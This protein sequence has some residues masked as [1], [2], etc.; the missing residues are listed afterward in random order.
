MAEVKNSFLQSKMNKDL[1]DRLIPNGQYRDALN[2]S[3]GKA[4]NDDVGALEAVLGN[5]PM[6]DTGNPDLICIGQVADNQNN[7][8]FQFW[9]DYKDP[10]PGVMDPATSGDMR[11]TM[12]DATS[13]TGTLTTLVS[14]VFLNF[15][16]NNAFRI[17]GANVLEDL[18]FWTDNRNQPRK[19]N[20]TRA[21]S[22]PNYYTTEV[23]ISVAKYSPVLPAN[24][25]LEIPVITKSTSSKP[26][27][28]SLKFTVSNSDALKLHIGM[29]LLINGSLNID[30]YAIITNIDIAL[31]TPFDGTIT[32][33]VPS[34]FTTT[35]NTG[36]ILT[37]F[38]SSMTNEA[39]DPNWPGDPN[40]LKDKYIRMSYRYKFDDGEYSLMAP[41]TQVLFIPNQNGYFLSG[42]EDAAYRST[43]VSWMENYINN[44]VLHILLP[45]TGN[46]I[47][48][49]YKITNIE[50]LYKESESLVVKALESI[51]LNGIQAVAGNTNL[52]IYNYRS[53]KPYKTLPESQ[54]VRVYD[55]VPV[56][57]RA[58][59]IVGNRVIYGNYISQNTPPANI[60][61]N[62]AITKKTDL[63]DSWAEYPNHTLKQNRNYQVGIILADKFGR[64]SS[65]ILSSNDALITSG[66]TSFGGSTVY[67]PYLVESLVTSVKEWRGN[68][69]AMIINSPITSIRNEGAGTPGLYAIVDGID[70]NN[71]GFQIT[72]GT[73]SQNNFSCNFASSPAQR[74]YPKPGNY[75]RGK[76]TDYV[77]VLTVATF[78]F[79]IVTSASIDADGPISDI[80]NYTGVIPDIK[81]SYD[82]NPLG[83]YSYKIVVR[84]QQQDYYNV[85]L[86]GILNGYPMF[87]TSG[88]AGV[89][90][91]IFPSN[92]VNR[93]AH[94]VLI[95]DN[96]NKIPRDLLEVGPDQKQYRSSVEIFGRVENTLIG[97]KT[98]NKQ[99]DPSKKA[100][101]V[102]TI[103]TANEL[104][105]LV[106][107][108]PDN[109]K[110]T[111]SNN[112]YQLNTTPIIAR[113]STVNR[114]GVI[115]SNS[116]LGTDP[117]SVDNTMNPFLSIY[118][119]A[120]T[121]S[122]LDLFW[123]TSTSGLISDI[124]QDV[125]TGSDSI[126]GF[127]NLG[128]SIFEWQNPN[129]LNYTNIN[130]NP[131][132]QQSPFITNYFVPVNSTGI[133]VS[134]TNMT[135]TVQDLGGNNRTSNFELYKETSGVNIGKYAI[136][137]TN[138][139]PFVYLT[140]A[141]EIESYQF[142]FTIINTN[143]SQSILNA[144]GALKNNTPIITSP[145]IGQ[146]IIINNTTP[147]A[148]LFCNGS[149]GANSS[150]VNMQQLQWTITNASTTGW[151]TYFSINANTG[152]VALINANFPV[153]TPF[154]LV[155][156]LTD[157]YNFT[158]NSAGIGSLYIES[159]ATITYQQQYLQP[160]CGVWDS[161]LVESS[162]GSIR[163]RNITSGYFNFWRLIPPGE[164]IDINN[165]TLVIYGY[166][167]NG[168]SGIYLT[169]T[170]GKITFTPGSF[171]G[172]FNWTK[173]QLNAIYPTEN[174]RFSGNLVTSGGSII[175]LNPNGNQSDADEINL[176]E[177]SRAD[178]CSFF[179][180]PP[181]NKSWKLINTNSGTTVTW[182]A[183]L[184]DRATIVSTVLSPGQ[185]VGSTFYGGDYTCIV[186]DSLNYTL[187]GAPTFNTCS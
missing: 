146:N 31:T 61:Y 76:Y 119:T 131:G 49:A 100:D 128:F 89:N 83:W 92:E 168:G 184:Q 142:K 185:Q 5:E 90:K 95:N 102:S 64:Q 169:P 29:Q 148:V 170:Q 13:G 94:T 134:I 121:V 56:R 107:N 34:A 87:Q 65:V 120:P 130:L 173:D 85:Y 113:I 77:K 175:T 20:I 159:N 158:T 19:I 24:V 23:Q 149:N 127:D 54:T 55:K 165:T 33:S 124:N 141:S 112:F 70:N 103:G 180:Y 157:T 73:V 178:N 42:D 86:P 110:G 115:A 22:N 186:E 150:L 50:I 132:T 117:P 12:Y 135:L 26:T 46:K 164:T 161:V 43:V 1:D 163:N 82:I 140:T 88:T 18:L 67:S 37:F 152:E 10:T 179:Y 14:G 147:G 15:A 118:E 105:F 44:I 97:I 35:I 126:V 98:S 123:E 32:V 7:R 160:F 62:V 21:F 59:E 182:S 81:F 63:F 40:Y 75:L 156:R 68:T 80:Y 145:T 143:N 69:L 72:S 138:V 187:G 153:D 139:N 58:Q 166:N 101:V 174:M 167:F 172:T 25:Y 6:V 57:A 30:D 111:A 122:L 84:Q 129:G 51:S 2:I 108:D 136:K 11:I 36:S 3:V 176:G 79:P 144:S 137:I 74:N 28:E 91:S 71:N 53:Q 181:T 93:T 125:L 8:V 45:E 155:I 162:P 52:Y 78:G 104:N 66:N 27:T 17:I 9:T 99:Y 171:S 47:S 96:I 48:D 133:P 4:E 16:N 114:I 116:I 177:G 39:E 38:G 41:F 183:L 154:N 106:L 60:D 151:E 109:K